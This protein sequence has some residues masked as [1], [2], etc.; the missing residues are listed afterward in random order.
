MRIIR[1]MPSI[2]AILI[3]PITQASTTPRTSAGRDAATAH[4]TDTAPAF[5]RAT[6]TIR[7]GG[8]PGTTGHIQRAMTASIGLACSSYLEAASRSACRSR[9]MA[10]IAATGRIARGV[11]AAVALR[12]Q[13]GI[14]IG[15]ALIAGMVAWDSVTTAFITAAISHDISM[16]GRCIPLLTRHTPISMSRIIELDTAITGGLKTHTAI[17]PFPISRF[18]Q[19]MTAGTS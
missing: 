2:R 11:I 8:G 6:S 9:A 16:P 18:H 7:A 12:S 10:M 17:R 1:I 5:T 15:D 19:A 4:V 14:R 13:G 3:T